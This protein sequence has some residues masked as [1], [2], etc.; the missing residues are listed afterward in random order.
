MAAAGVAAAGVDVAGVADVLADPLS[1][2]VAQVVARL[3]ALPDDLNVVPECAVISMPLTTPRTATTIPI[4]TP[5]WVLGCSSRL[6]YWRA[7]LRR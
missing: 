6:R 3:T 4:I 2:G 7:T 5:R 1:E